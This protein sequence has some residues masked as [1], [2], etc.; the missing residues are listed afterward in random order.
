MPKRGARTPSVLTDMADA[1]GRVTA[2][3]M[4]TLQEWKSGNYIGVDE[5][6]I[7]AKERQVALLMGATEELS[8]MATEGMR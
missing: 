4:G 2:T 7:E 8:K 5:R 3:E 6:A 1:V